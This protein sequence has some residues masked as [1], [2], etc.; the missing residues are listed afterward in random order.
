MY[1]LS[2][3]DLLR[4]KAQG[5]KANIIVVGVLLIDRSIDADLFSAQVASIKIYGKLQ[6]PNQLQDIL[7]QK[8]RRYDA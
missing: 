6:A 3:G 7:T 4:L 8:Q 5:K 2:S 1:R